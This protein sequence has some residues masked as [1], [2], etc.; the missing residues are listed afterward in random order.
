MENLAE[1][2]RLL[3]YC[4]VS[5]APYVD[6]EDNYVRYS[7][8]GK[9][10]AYLTAG[11]PVIITKVPAIAFE[12]EKRKCGIAIDYDKRQL[13]SAVVKLLINKTTLMN[14]RKNAYKM[15]KEYRWD[16]VFANAFKQSL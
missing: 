13:V 8:P 12:I 2:E 6:S 10:K 5:V 11:L 7:D 14:Y 15:G 4:A 9:V 3:S 16:K 1:V